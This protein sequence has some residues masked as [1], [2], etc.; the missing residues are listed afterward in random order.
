MEDTSS[1]ELWVN[2]SGSAPY[3]ST[4][5]RSVA[6]CWV[7]LSG[8]PSMLAVPPVIA[9][10]LMLGAETTCPSSTIATCACGELGFC[11]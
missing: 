4:L 6:Y 8:G 1:I 7:K 5:A 9:P 10:R 11:W 2:S 3:F